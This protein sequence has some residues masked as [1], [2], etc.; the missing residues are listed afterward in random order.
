MNT[1][2]FFRHVF[3]PAM[4]GMLV[5]L[6]TMPA[7]NVVRVDARGLGTE[8]ASH[9]RTRTNGIAASA[10]AM[11]VLA[12]T[13]LGR[14]RRRFERL[15]RHPLFR[16]A[17]ALAV[18]MI[19][20]LFD[21]RALMAAPIAFGATATEGQHA[22]EFLLEERM[23]VGRP[24]REN[25]TVLS[26]Q[27]LK[28]GAVIGRV[29][30]GIGRVSIPTVVGGAGNGTVNTVFAGPEVEIGNYLLSLVTGV[31]DGG[32]WSLT[33]PSGK[34]LPNLTMTPGAGGSTVYTSRHINFTI[35]DGSTDFSGAATFTFVV[36]TTAPTV[37]GGTGTG[38]MTALSLGPDAKPGR[39]QVINRVVIANGGDFEV[40]GPD[41][42][43]VGRFNWANSGSTAA[44]TSRQVNFTLSDATDYIA[45]N[46]FD[47]AVFNQLSGGKVVAF[48]PTTFDGRHRADGAL[49]DAVD[50]TSGDLAGVIVTRDATLRLADLQWATAISESEKVSAQNDLLRRQI[51]C[52]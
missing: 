10:V 36:S 52:R 39:Y 49:Y 22:G 37:I 35:V 30:L 9:W 50:A 16:P 19:I 21:H 24:S 15:S 31:A 28:A 38:V 23:E 48:D 41:G 45:N 46:Y 32:V 8:H 4:L 43:S 40:I 27:N 18:V 34:A 14:V 12:L 51:V 25:I 20:V 33:T 17:V 6:L 1:R 11:C 3:L 44:F 7:L 29:R 5:G 47:I 26:G 42:T 13:W 2:P